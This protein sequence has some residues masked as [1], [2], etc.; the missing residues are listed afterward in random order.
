[1]PK[2]DSLSAVKETPIE[3]PVNALV[4]VT[5]P[6]V[7]VMFTVEPSPLWMSGALPPPVVKITP[8]LTGRPFP[9]SEPSLAAL[10]VEP[11]VLSVPAVPR[12][13]RFPSFTVTSPATSTPSIRLKSP[14]LTCVVAVE[15]SPVMLI[16]PSPDDSTRLPARWPRP[17]RSRR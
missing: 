3:L 2:S 16:E 17:R 10:I 9:P 14:P 6:P 15:V 1:M 8:A 5:A 12:M 13:V 7:P 11:E 4:V